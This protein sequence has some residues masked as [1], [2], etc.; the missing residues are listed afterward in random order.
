MIEAVGEGVAKALGRR[1]RVGVLRRPGSASGARRREYTV[2]PVEQA[3]PLPAA[4]RFELGASLGIPAL[5]AYH[6][7]FADGPIDGRRVLV[8][9]GAGAVGP[10]RD[11]AGAVGRGAR[12]STTVSSDEK[13]ELAR[14]AD[15]A[16]STTAS[17]APRSGSAKVDRIVEVALGPNLELDLAVA[18]P[19]AVISTYAA[20]QSRRP[21]SRS[22]R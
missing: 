6:C 1:A 4:R 17:R 10:R 7:L 20:D 22:A 9:G 8:A 12:W 13:A 21:R 2:V 16:S 5:T 15:A 3:V 14:A 19:H 11:R 18:N